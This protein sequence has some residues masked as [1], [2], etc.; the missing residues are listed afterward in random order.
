M[1]RGIDEAGR[2]TEPAALLEALGRGWVGR[3]AIEGRYPE[4]WDTCIRRYDDERVLL[5]PPCASW[6]TVRARQLGWERYLESLRALRDGRD[7]GHRLA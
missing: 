1:D 7:V 6:D 4:P 5:L 2:E 3:V